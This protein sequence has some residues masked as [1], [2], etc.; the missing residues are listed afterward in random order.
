MLNKCQTKVLNY[1]CPNYI[2]I[3][4]E[5]KVSPEIDFLLVSFQIN[6][7]KIQIYLVST[8]TY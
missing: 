8:R 4:I 6:F 1:V 2:N 7:E 3:I 5:L